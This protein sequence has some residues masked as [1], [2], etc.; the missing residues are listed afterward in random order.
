M[1]IDELKPALELRSKR[2]E[3]KS[4]IVLSN[5]GRHDWFIDWLIDCSKIVNVVPLFEAWT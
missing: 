1:Q 4:E 5:S 3:A 2:L